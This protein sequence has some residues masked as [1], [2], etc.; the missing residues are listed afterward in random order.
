MPSLNRNDK[1]TC[2][3]CGTRNTK[4]NLAR[5]KKSCSVGALYC[6]QCPNFSTKSQIN[7]NYHIA[8]THSAPKL[9][10]TFKCKLCF[11]EFPGFYALR[12]HRNTQHGLQ[13]GS[14]TRGVE[15]KV[16][17][18]EDHRLREELR[19]CQRSLVDSELERARHKVFNYAVETLNETVVNEKLWSFFQQCEMCSKSESGFWLHFEKYRRRRVQIFLRT[20]KHYP[21]GSIQTC[22]HPWRLGKVERLSQT[23]LTSYSLVAEKEWTQSGSST[24]LQT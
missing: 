4:L 9:Y 1:V 10:I 18:V 22:V 17:D 24:N 20:R 5:H 7:L 6:T 14:G 16:G 8:K 15:H 23:K 2:E 19:S 3:K 21:G 11:Q 13:I 12:Q